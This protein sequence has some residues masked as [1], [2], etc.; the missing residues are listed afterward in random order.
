MGIFTKMEF[1]FKPK[2]VIFFLTTFTFIFALYTLFLSAPA[3]AAC[4]YSGST[5]CGCAGCEA[6]PDNGLYEWGEGECKIGRNTGVG[7][8]CYGYD[9]ECG[10]GSCGYHSNCCGSCGGPGDGGPPVP[11]Y[12]VSG[13]VRD[14]LTGIGLPGVQ[15]YIHQV[16]SGSV[17]IHSGTDLNGYYTFGDKVVAGEEYEVHSFYTAEYLGD[18]GSGVIPAG[19]PVWPPTYAPANHEGFAKTTNPSLNH[20]TSLPVPLGYF[21]YLGQQASSES[22]DDCATECN[23]VFDPIGF[24]NQ[25]ASTGCGVINSSYQPYVDLGWDAVNTATTYVISVYDYSGTEYISYSRGAVDICTGSRC[26]IRFPSSGS[27]LHLGQNNWIVRAYNGGATPIA[28][29]NIN[30]ASFNVATCTPYQ[31]SGEFHE[32]NY[33]EDTHLCTY[34]QPLNADADLSAAYVRFEFL[35]GIPPKVGTINIPSSSY[36]I[37]GVYGGPGD[38]VAVPS[39]PHKELPDEISYDIV[40]IQK[41]PGSGEGDYIV[42]TGSAI[43][44]VADG[45]GDLSDYNFGYAL[46]NQFDLG[47]FASYNGDTYGSTINSADIPQTVGGNLKPY[48]TFSSSNKD[49]AVFGNNIS[50]NNIVEG[51]KYINGFTGDFWP[52]NF[53][54][55]PPVG[56]E[57]GEGAGV[58]TITNYGQFQSMQTGNIYQMTIDDFMSYVL[59]NPGFSGT[60]SLN[61]DAPGVSVLYL[62]SDNPLT[63][64]VVFSNPFVSNDANKRLLLII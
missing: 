35:G 34:R 41:G 62:T 5:N 51:D 58:A 14:S 60:Y 26:T 59:E 39:L 24:Q 25:S 49:V 22:R 55:E 6:G 43:I 45:H 50:V 17:T 13:Y 36:V 48:L 64:S 38:V 2:K 31:I 32:V 20:N 37:S 30:V 46:R 52:D 15:V 23:F 42:S 21:A 3:Y 56:G 18:L 47:W 27:S 11:R 40:C 54:F 28:E 9:G 33:D 8:S 1:I 19:T 63:S 57:T 4:C 53:S 61:G 29:S 16:A 12:P 44:D 7:E 10:I